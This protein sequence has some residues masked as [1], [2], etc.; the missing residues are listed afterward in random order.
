MEAPMSQLRILLVDDEIQVLKALGRTFRKEGYEIFTASDGPGALEILDQAE[1]DLVIADQMMPGMNGIELL[2]RVKSRYPWILRM[3]L[4]GYPETSIARKAYREAGTYRVLAKP[5]DPDH[6]RKLV[7]Y[8]HR[9][10]ELQAQCEV[11]QD[12][13]KR[14]ETELQDLLEDCPELDQVHRDVDGNLVF[15]KPAAEGEKSAAIEPA[16]REEGN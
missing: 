10:L 4:T 12:S 16:E 13:L 3:I 15:E 7:R 2:K 11:L 1:I 6:L 14:S 9:Y 8:A 5:W